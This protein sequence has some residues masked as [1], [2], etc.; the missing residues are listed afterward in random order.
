MLTFQ[1]T[2]GNY[3]NNVNPIFLPKTKSPS[4]ILLPQE[5][6]IEL[7]SLKSG[8]NIAILKKFSKEYKRIVIMVAHKSWKIKTL[9][10]AVGFENGCIQIWKINTIKTS[11]FCTVLKGH[12]NEISRLH[13]H[14]EKCL[15]LSGCKKGCFVFWD[16]DK[17]KGILR[18]KKAH[19]GKIDFLLFT[20]KTKYFFYVIISSGADNLIK[21]WNTR[22]GSCLKIINIGMR[23]DYGL[24]IKNDNIIIFSNKKSKIFF[25]KFENLF[26]LKVE[27][28]IKVSAKLSEPTILMSKKKNIIFIYGKNRKIEILFLKKNFRL[29][30]TYDRKLTQKKEIQKYSNFFKEKVK[31]LD[32]WEKKNSKE[33]FLLVQYCSNFLDVFKLVFPFKTECKEQLKFINIFQNNP[34]W[35]QGDIRELIWFSNDFLLASLSGFSKTINIWFLHSQKCPRILP[36]NSKGLC[37]ALNTNNNILVG[38]KE[39][40]LELFDIYSGNLIFSKFNAHVGPIWSLEVINDFFQLA[41][42]GTDGNLKLWEFGVNGINLLKYLEI[43]DQILGMKIMPKKNIIAVNCLSSKLL[44]FR[45]SNLQFSFSFDGYSMPIITLAVDHEDC[46]LVTGSADNLLRI[47]NLNQKELKKSISYHES[48]ITSV[49]FQK[50][51]GNLFSGSRN[52]KICFWKEKNY[53][54]LSEINNFHRGPVWALSVSENGKFLASGSQCK[55]LILWRIDENLDANTKNFQKN[56]EEG[57]DYLSQFS[58]QKKSI[59][60]ELINTDQQNFEINHSFKSRKTQEINQLE[61]AK[62]IFSQISKNEWLNFIKNNKNEQVLSFLNLIFENLERCSKNDVFSNLNKIIELFK[63]SREINSNKQTN[64]WKL[65]E[66]KIKLYTNRASKIVETNLTTLK[67]LKKCSENKRSDLPDSN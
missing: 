65:I 60:N 58:S 1:S 28:K 3:S 6:F 45:F 26:N 13:Y 17:K 48:S 39:G 36:L 35:C 50:F 62:K 43:G 22:S 46:L 9:S 40:G 16:I 2:L 7:F 52:G 32:F 20:E 24:G 57:V 63:I 54:L 31:T 55:K 21:F 15:L 37:M 66:R 49:C 27:K 42:G 61:S 5:N 14:E 38:T 29:D 67:L 53:T 56:I 25:I 19:M 11:I 47:W 59:I 8:K 23:I 30:K 18:V 41:S 64:E 10:I 44:F 12:M 4:I 33:I 51:N 34:H